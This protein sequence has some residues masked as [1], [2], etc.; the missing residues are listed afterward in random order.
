MLDFQPQDFGRSRTTL[1]CGSGGD[2]FYLKTGFCWRTKRLIKTRDLQN[3]L[4]YFNLSLNVVPGLS[5]WIRP[6]GNARENGTYT[7]H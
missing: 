1:N 4:N 3:C 5:A 2:I 6:C 7:S